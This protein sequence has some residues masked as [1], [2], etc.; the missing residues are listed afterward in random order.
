MARP[1]LILLF[2]GIAGPTFA[3]PDD[4]PH[5]RGPNANGTAAPT[6]DPPVEWSATRNI[7]WK[8]DLPG[9]GSATPIIWGD[10]VFVVTA[11]KTDRRATP[12]D[13]PKV[14]P[15]FEKKTDPPTHF[16]EFLVL[17]FDRTTGKLKWKQ[18]AAEKVPHEGHHETH[19]YAAGSPT[20]DGERLYV[21][22]GSFGLFCYTLD[23]KPVWDRDL[24]RMNTRLGWGEAVT[25]VVHGDSL[26]VNWDQEADSKLLC[27]DTK[28]GK[29]KWEAPRDERTS[30]TTPLVV[31]RKG[32]TQ[33]IMNGTGHVRAYDLATGKPLWT[34]PPMT[35]NAIPSA[36]AADGVAYVL[37]GYRGAVG[38]ALPIDST[39]EVEPIW[40]ISKGTPYV[41]SPLLANGRLYFTQANA[42]LLTIL[43]AKSGKVVLDQERLP[44]VRSLYGSPVAAAGRVYLTDRDGTTLVFKEGDKFELL[45]TNR[46][47]D[48]IDASPVAVGKQLFLRSHGA[49]Y[50]IEAPAAR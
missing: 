33:V 11:A 24:G 34:G 28:T 31:E 8:A 6:A 27:L 2:A 29:T 45:A 5:W 14:D 18:T 9:K 25:P 26:L 21:S 40:K 32:V 36:V 41:P 44:G 37:S 19:S 3:G 30:W 4:W 16:Y 39:G 43:D 46:L 12:G 10:A 47:N 13:L 7:R 49:L 15:K 42:N 50:C 38:V 23:G 17:A 22:F 35:V 48:P 1:V 20:T